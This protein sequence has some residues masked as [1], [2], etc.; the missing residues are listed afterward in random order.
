MMPHCLH[1]P[2]RTACCM[3]LSACPFAGTRMTAAEWA[4]HPP[5]DG[6]RSTRPLVLAAVVTA[7]EC[8]GL[9]TRTQ[10][11]VAA[12]RPVATRTTPTNH[13]SWKVRQQLPLACCTRCHM[14]CRQMPGAA[15]LGINLDHIR[16]KTEIV[17]KS[18][19]QRG[20][21]MDSEILA[22]ADMAGPLVFC[23]AL[24]G[25]LL[26]VSSPS[27][28]RLPPPLLPIR[29]VAAVVLTARTYNLEPPLRCVCCLWSS[30][31]KYTSAQSMP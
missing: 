21:Q 11:L 4:R 26:L 12:Q 31:G 5:E 24:G 22:D 30:T 9:P 13:R 29:C 8:I 27:L 17:L 23:L 1:G 20:I 28:L 25:A 6:Q 2:C 7:E 18:A 16:K 10:W 14:A 19:Y 15:E 3:L